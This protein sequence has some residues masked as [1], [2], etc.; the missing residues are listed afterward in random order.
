MNTIKTILISLIPLICAAITLLENDMLNSVYGI[1]LV[2]HFIWPI[3][4]PIV[5]SKINKAFSTIDFLILL[6]NILLAN[7]TIVGV[8]QV[9]NFSFES[10]LEYIVIIVPIIEVLLTSYYLLKTNKSKTNN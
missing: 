5:I 10:H 9:M 3:V 8:E 6:A 7:I 1:I 2:T 4:L